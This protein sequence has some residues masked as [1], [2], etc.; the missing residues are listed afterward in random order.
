MSEKLPEHPQYSDVEP[1]I[2]EFKALKDEYDKLIE[3]L[4]KDIPERPSELQSYVDSW[5]RIK[6]IRN[7]FNDAGKIKNLK[8][9]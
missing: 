2:L 8:T 3:D 4:P 1:E 9:N 7:I 6:E 5:N